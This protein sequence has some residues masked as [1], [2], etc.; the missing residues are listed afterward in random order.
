MPTGTVVPA[1]GVTGSEQPAALARAIALTMERLIAVDALATPAPAGMPIDAI[2][3]RALIMS[4]RTNLE[5]TP[6]CR[7]L[8]RHDGVGQRLI[9]TALQGRPAFAAMLCGSTSATTRQIRD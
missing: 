6:V 2:P 4:A 3:R 8:L 9:E 5:P 1:V 7:E